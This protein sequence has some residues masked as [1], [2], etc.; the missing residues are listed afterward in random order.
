MVNFKSAAA[1]MNIVSV[2]KADILNTDIWNIWT[3][4]TTPSKWNGYL[5]IQELSLKLWPWCTVV[6]TPVHRCVVGTVFLCEWTQDTQ[7]LWRIYGIQILAGDASKL[8]RC[9]PNIGTVFNL[10]IPI[11]TNFLCWSNLIDLIWLFIGVRYRVPH[12]DLNLGT[13]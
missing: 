7:Y 3:L 1:L 11:V 2:P 4:L 12:K 10:G 5:P 6:V 13:P 9:I 8:W